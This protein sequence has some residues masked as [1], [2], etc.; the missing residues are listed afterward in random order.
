MKRKLC[1]HLSPQKSLILG[2][3]PLL[4]REREMHSEPQ[5]IVENISFSSEDPSSPDGRGARGTVI[6]PQAVRQD[7]EQALKAAWDRAIAQQHR[8]HEEI[9]RQIVASEP[10][11]VLEEMTIGPAEHV[12]LHTAAAAP[13]SIPEDLHGRLIPSSSNTAPLPPSPFEPYQ[14][15]SFGLRH[16]LMQPATRQRVQ[17]GILRRVRANGTVQ[18]FEFSMQLPGY[19]FQVL[20]A[21]KMVR[22]FTPYFAISLDAADINR[23]SISYMGK[24]RASSMGGSHW[25]LF[26]NGLRERDLNER[27]PQPPLQ[28]QQ[29]RRQL[30]AVSFERNVTG[31]PGPCCLEAVVPLVAHRT[32]EA[33]AVRPAATQEVDLLQRWRERECIVSPSEQAPPDGPALF[34]LRSRRATWDDDLQAFTLDYEGRAMHPS[35][36]NVQL[37]ASEAGRSPGGDVAFSADGSATGEAASSRHHFQMGKLGTDEFAVD[38]QWPLSP[39][40]AFGLALA[41]SDGK[42]ALSRRLSK[43]SMAP[44]V[45]SPRGTESQSDNRGYSLDLS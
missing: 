21:R 23:D 35:V 39:L 42:L 12:E 29:P 44:V 16:A 22:S 4:S 5:L 24:L 6:A 14:L 1:S 32:S 27:N 28:Q 36:K 10:P 37:V 38:W 31:T 7:D 25:T 40:A 3:P 20:A 33:P 34:G 30:L 9:H 26:D 18:R 8:I 41:I 43:A 45:P 15:Q 13:S 17:R 19:E 2:P 11:L